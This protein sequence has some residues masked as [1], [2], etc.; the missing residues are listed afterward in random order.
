MSLEKIWNGIIQQQ[1]L[2]KTGH[3]SCVVIELIYFV[4]ISFTDNL[5]TFR[6]KSMLVIEKSI[7][8]D[9]SQK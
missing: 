7:I 1:K 2:V 3:V 5:D 6:E 8:I 9:Y 4:A